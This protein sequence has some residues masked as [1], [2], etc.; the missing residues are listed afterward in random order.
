MAILGSAAILTASPS[1]VQ[2]INIGAIHNTTLTLSTS[3]WLEPTS[4]QTQLA[5]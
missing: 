5:V 1:N 3:G 4:S 2:V